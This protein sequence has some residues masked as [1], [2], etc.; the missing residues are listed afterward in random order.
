MH[1]NQ[2]LFRVVS[3]R[4]QF[5]LAVVF[6]L[7]IALIARIAYLQTAMHEQL[8]S[9]GENRFERVLKFSVQRGNI[10]DRNGQI[11][12]TSAPVDSLAAN[13]QVFCRSRDRW[14]ELASSVGVDMELMHERCDQYSDS[15]FMY[16]L[17][18]I[19]P[20]RAQQAID[21]GVP[22]LEVRREYQRF[23][24]GGPIGAQL[25][26]LTDVKDTGQE[27][28]ELKYDEL[29]TGK[30][31][32]QRVLKDR[33]GRYVEA[34]DN[35]SSVRH[36]AD[37]QISID[38]R[39][40]TLA[41]RY[42]EDAVKTHKAAAGSIVLIKVPSGEI[43]SMVNAP[44][45]NPNDRT[46]VTHGVLRNRVVTDAIEP[47][48]L[49]KPFTIAMLLEE[50]RVTPDTVVDT[51]PGQMYIGR[52]RISD[53]RDYG[54]L[55][56]TDIIAK[57]SNVGTVKLALK[58]PFGKLHRTLERVG[59]GNAASD[60]PGESS[61]ALPVRKRP[62]EHATMSFG[63]GFSA[64]ALQIARAYTVFATDGVLLP[65]T[66]E[67]KP[68]GYAALGERV[69]SSETTLQIRQMLRK[70][71]TRH[72]TGSKA[73]ISGYDVGGKTGT[74][75]KLVDG[76]YENKDYLS[77]FAGFA[78]LSN[79]QFVGV[80]VIDEPRSKQYFGGAVA[81]PVFSRLMEDV[82]RI[83]DV[84]PDKLETLVTDAT[85]AGGGMG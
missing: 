60:L 41:T 9:E 65:I 46:T 11:L 75:H 31:G 38:Q 43:I 55:A 66:L 28:L 57:S 78:P 44:Q 58:E 52:S 84:R 42:L 26:G 3:G 34:I 73:R 10:L 24:P 27:G 82:M 63:Y 39:I 18:R 69:Y 47:G 76:S 40:Q 68:A 51:H 48:S 62:I 50:G 29:L 4:M 25:I 71:T 67:P 23:F 14:E 8:V 72:G 53:I 35:P 49:T 20:E 33:I 17:K 56:V 1:R 83:Y 12:S 37:L 15:R 32:G 13:P 54:E 61:G 22:G 80:V 21:L 16:V 19:P 74:T 2:N 5:V 70:V 64:T 30:A 36:G 6:G 45:F 77:L 59:F 7:F 81:A 85:P 79:P